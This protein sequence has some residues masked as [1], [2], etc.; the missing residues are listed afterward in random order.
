MIM[1]L[2]CI[3]LLGKIISTCRLFVSG[4]VLDDLGRKEQVNSPER[5]CRF[6]THLFSMCIILPTYFSTHH[7]I[8]HV[9]TL[10]TW[11]WIILILSRFNVTLNHVKDEVEVIPSSNPDSLDD[12]DQ[13]ECIRLLKDSKI[14]DP[15]QESF[16]K[17]SAD[18]TYHESESKSKGKSG[19]LSVFVKHKNLHFHKL[20]IKRLTFFKLW[21]SSFKISTSQKR[22]WLSIS[23]HNLRDICP[24][25]KPNCPDWG[26]FLWPTLCWARQV[27]PSLRKQ[28]SG[29]N[30]LQDSWKCVS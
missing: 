6:H 24:R 29:E 26:R 17:L 8:D 19:V 23:C 2:K 18:Q 16:F 30:Q 28:Y 14:N 20:N 3:P 4:S 25:W 5:C 21:H 13:D 27:K 12:P 9:L 11:W 22:W 10:C 15:C 7:F 1:H